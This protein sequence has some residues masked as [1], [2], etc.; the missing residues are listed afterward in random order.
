MCDES[1]HHFFLLSLNQT[2]HCR[3]SVFDWV[4]E[5]KRPKRSSS[6]GKRFHHCVHEGFPCLFC[7]AAN[8]PLFPLSCSPSSSLLLF[9]CHLYLCESLPICDL[10]ASSFLVFL[11][12]SLFLLSLSPSFLTFFLHIYASSLCSYICGGGPYWSDLMLQLPQPYDTQLRG[13]PRR[14]ELLINPLYIFSLLQ[15][16]IQHY[17]LM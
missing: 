11:T 1:D 12:L 10:S 3:F 9:L 7:T 15:F 5:R 6:S 14:P 13:L 2:Q 8:Q 4:K 17:L 16:N